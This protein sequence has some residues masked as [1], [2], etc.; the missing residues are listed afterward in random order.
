LDA[1]ALTHWEG[2]KARKG[3]KRERYRYFERG[4]WRFSSLGTFLRVMHGVARRHGRNPERL[5]QCKTL[6][7]QRAA[8]DRELA[9]FFE[10]KMVRGLAKLPFLLH[11]LGVPP[12]QFE[13]F[14]SQAVPGG[15]LEEYRLRV[16]RLACDFP[17]QE[18]YFAWQAF[19]ARYDTVNRR[20]IPDY[21]KAEHF[22]PLKAA[23]PKVR[24]HLVSMTELLK[25]QPAQSQNRFVLLDAQDWMNAG[26][27]TDL[28]RQIARVGE[29]NTRIIFRSGGA[30]SPIEGAL[31]AELR[32]RFTY[33]SELSARLF[34]QDRSAIYGGFHVYEMN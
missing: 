29:P 25:R 21:L 2:G 3:L 1:A 6:A 23:A 33:L 19:G 16:K 34:R 8:F 24:H 28:W 12:R 22:A 31:P 5:L 11:G 27:I 20:A 15:V 7:E 13:Q 26:Q 10:M 14:K 4:L 9:P 30:V 17:M 32:G 18:N